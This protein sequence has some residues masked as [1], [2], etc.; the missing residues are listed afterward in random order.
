[1]EP[2]QQLFANP[3]AGQSSTPSGLRMVT[4][5]GDNR[6]VPAHEW[7]YFFERFSAAR[8]FTEP[9]AIDEMSRYL[10]DAIMKWYI[11]AIRKFDTFESLK[12]DFLETFKKE[13]RDEYWEIKFEATEGVESF[14]KKKAKVAREG[15]ISEEICCENMVTEL[16]YSYQWIFKN[17]VRPLSYKRFLHLAQMVWICDMYNRQTR[18]GQANKQKIGGEQQMFNRQSTGQGQSFD[19]NTDGNNRVKRSVD[20]EPKVCFFCDEPGHF[21]RDCPKKKAQASS[22]KFA[23]ARQINTI[24]ASIER[25]VN[26]LEASEPTDENNEFDGLKDLF[27]DN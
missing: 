9:E 6:S 5:T 27:N 11:C 10:S 12:R 25:R 21:A 4:F 18:F 17:E 23:P 2:R 20:G 7:M 1:M 13:E 14:M 16:P 8:N 24:E 26:L 15:G 19:K 22:K 3:E